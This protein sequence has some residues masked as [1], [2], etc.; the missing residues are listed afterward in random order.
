[1]IELTQ[2]IG[3]S[4]H[5]VA[6]A[7]NAYASYV[8]RTPSGVG[9]AVGTAFQVRVTPALATWFSVDEGAVR[10]SNAGASVVAIAGQVTFSHVAEAPERP[11]FRVHGEGQVTEIGNVWR[12]AGQT[13]AVH[14]ET[15]FVGSPGVGDWVSVEGHVDGRGTR[16]ADRIVL[17]RRSPVEHF[18]LVGQVDAIGADAW[19]VNGQAVLVV[20]GTDIEERIEVGDLVC[21]EGTIREDGAL[22][23]E[24]ILQRGN[25]AVG[26]T[27]S[28]VGV[29]QLMST[30][31]WEISDVLVAVNEATLTDEELLPGSVVLARGDVLDDGTWLARTIRQ[32]RTQERTFEFVGKVERVDPWI[33]AGIELETRLYTVFDEGIG[34]DD[35]VRV[36]GIILS[37]GAWVAE[38]IKWDDQ[39]GP[40][41][42]FVGTVEQTDPWQVRGTTLVVG[43]HTEIDAGVDIGSLVRVEGHASAQLGWLAD[44]IALASEARSGAGCIRQ[45]SVVTSATQDEI[46]LLNGVVLARSGVMLEKGTIERGAVVEAW[47]CTDSSGQVQVVSITV[48]G[49]VDTDTLE[50]PTVE[51]SPPDVAA[52]DTENG[53]ADH[54]K[55]LVC[56][57]GQTIEVD[58]HAL[59]GH[60]AH[61]DT[62]GPCPDDESSDSSA[63]PEPVR[64]VKPTKKPDREK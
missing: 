46:V 21:V 30:G 18:T 25:G 50:T 32:V 42:A 11:V 12:I 39:D 8:V 26:D 1:V 4:D 58:E 34:E 54:V 41:F 53:D 10:V 51:P 36:Q 60:L 55:F 31:A 27:F 48:V 16:Y 15:V 57:K 24:H 49:H 45:F 37:N 33:V 7:A 62:Q 28:F 19:T 44:R 47:V 3:E 59:P 17:L 40:V 52:P 22:V 2:W 38:T 23:A 61:G 5:D 20:S 64:P 29:V 9:T 43:D 6:R 56:H 63:Q 13:F 14:A 35:Q